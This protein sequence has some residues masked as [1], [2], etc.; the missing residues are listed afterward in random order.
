MAA[1]FI[2][3]W[4][5]Q[6][7]LPAAEAPSTAGNPFNALIDLRQRHAAAKEILVRTPRQV[8]LPSS[9]PLQVLGD[10]E[11]RVTL[12]LLLDPANAKH[13]QQLAQWLELRRRGIRTELRFVPAGESMVGSVVWQLALKYN[14]TAVLWEALNA[15][16]ADLDDTALLGLLAAQGV[17]L[18]EIRAALADPNSSL[19]INAQL[20][21]DWADR[22]GLQGPVALLDGLVVDGQ[23]LQPQ[24]LGLYLQRRLNNEAL[25][26]IDDYLL[27]RK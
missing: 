22:N 14:K 4:A 18:T 23:V 16:R 6:A 21:A 25:V 17:E 24:L 5:Y 19:L 1:A 20:A 12:T 8:E 27:M 10:T 9:P 13:R 11:G 3:R 15:A 26:Q 2:G 7:N